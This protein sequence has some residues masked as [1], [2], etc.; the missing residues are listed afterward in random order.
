MGDGLFIKVAQ[1]VAKNYPKI[2]YTEEQ[3]DTICMQLANNP[4]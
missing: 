4:N 1:E 3:I 2:K